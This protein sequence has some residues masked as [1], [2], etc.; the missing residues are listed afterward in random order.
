MIMMVVVAAGNGQGSSS[1]C[2]LVVVVAFS[3]F[4]RNFREGPT[5]Y[6]PPTLVLFLLFF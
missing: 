1:F 6:S 4:V 5:I 2:V 3:T